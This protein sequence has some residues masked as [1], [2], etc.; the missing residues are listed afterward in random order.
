MT[1]KK[2]IAIIGPIVDQGGR[3]VEVHFIATALKDLYEVTIFSTAGMTQQSVALPEGVSFSSLQEQLYLKYPKLRRWAN[4][5]SFLKGGRQPGFT[6]VNHPWVKSRVPFDS[7]SK[8]YLRDYVKHFDAL[9][10]C[11]QVASYGIREILEAAHAESIPVLIRITGTVEVIGKKLAPLLEKASMFLMHSQENAHRLTQYVSVPYRLIDQTA[12]FEDELLSHPILD[13]TISSLG[14]V[15]RLSE[16]KGVLPLLEHCS[17]HPDVQLTLIG[18]GPL[19]EDVEAFAQK[20]SHLIYK[21]S[22]SPKELSKFYKT[23]DVL[24]IPSYEESGPLV[25]LEAMAAGRLIMS[26]EVGAMPERLQ[27]T[28]NKFW[29]AVEDAQDFDRVL[30]RIVSL[31]LLEVQKIAQANRER[32]IAHYTREQIQK[33]YREAV[34]HFFQ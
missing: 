16:E 30:K 29:F 32:Y 1:V 15:G 4:W 21:G 13:K 23:F 25:G 8:A 2:K 14:Y 9:L 22:M 31:S 7:L 17:K 24:V 26:T 6:Y 11:T 33:K 27:G 10:L 18:E 34:A 12:Q 28:E 3:E 20:F 5:M 19:K